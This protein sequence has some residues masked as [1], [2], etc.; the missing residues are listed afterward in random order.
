LDGYA[1]SEAVLAG[2]GAREY[3]FFSLL[4]MCNVV[5]THPPSTSEAIAAQEQGGYRGLKSYKPEIETREKMK[6]G[7]TKLPA[8][9]RIS[10]RYDC[11][12]ELPSFLCHLIFVFSLIVDISGSITSPIYVRA[13]VFVLL[14]CKF[15]YISIIEELTIFLHYSLFFCLLGSI[16]VFCFFKRLFCSICN[17]LFILIIYLSLFFCTNHL[18]KNFFLKLWPFVDQ[19]SSIRNPFSVFLLEKSNW[20]RFFQCM[21]RFLMYGTYSTSTS[22]PGKDWKETGFCGYGDACKFMHDRGDYKSGWQLE[23][24]WDQQQER[25]R[26]KMLGEQVWSCTLPLCMFV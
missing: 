26:R 24:E 2:D 23:K 25:E 17:Y 3:I 10:C 21:A 9:V 14:F 16:F 7:P 4:S 12:R 13:P 5:R 18:K 8:N 11:S 22:L 15:Y 20:R 6:I 19:T 1:N